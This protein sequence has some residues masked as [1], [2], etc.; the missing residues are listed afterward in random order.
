MTNKEFLDFQKDF[1][2]KI[3]VTCEDKNKDYTSG[4]GD[5]FH[6][7]TLVEKLG[8]GTA[9]QCLLIRMSDK[10]ARLVTFMNTGKLS[11]ANESATDALMDIVGYA[12]IAAGLLKDQENITTKDIIKLVEEKTKKYCDEC[13]CK[14]PDEC[15]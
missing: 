13:T 6:N 8:I 3:M 2:A 12:S 1:F 4:S 9:L 5:A 11:V 14:E 10:Y 15:A 7:F